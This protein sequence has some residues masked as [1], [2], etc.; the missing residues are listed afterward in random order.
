MPGRAII[1]IRIDNSGSVDAIANIRKAMDD[2]GVSVVGVKEAGD[3]QDKALQKLLNSL[4]PTRVASEKL[5][6]SQ[7]ILSDAYA[8]GKI[9]QERFATNLDALNAKYS[10]H[11]SALDGLKNSLGDFGGLLDGLSS[12]LASFVGPAAIVAGVA[13]LGKAMVDAGEAAAGDEVVQARLTATWTANAGAAGITMEALQSLAQSLSDVSGMSLESIKNAEAL[14]LTFHDVTGN[15]FERMITDATD[16]AA[17]LGTDVGSAVEKLGRALENPV[18]GMN[19]LT[20]AGV[21]FTAAEKEQIKAVAQSG[22]LLGAQNAILDQVESRF[23][24]AAATIGDTTTGAW[25][26]FTNALH[27]LNVEVGKVVLEPAKV[28]LTSATDVV[29]EST[30]RVVQLKNAWQ[31]LKDFFEALGAGES[32]GTAAGAAWAARQGYSYASLPGMAVQ[33]PTQNGQ[34]VPLSTVG[35][36]SPTAG[37]AVGSSADYKNLADSA[38]QLT[39]SLNPLIAA[40]VAEAAAEKT[41]NDALAAG[42]LTPQRYTQL[43]AEEKNNLEATAASARS[44]YDAFDP[45]Q[46]AQDQYT[47]SVTNYNKE[48]LQGVIS[49]TQLAAAIAGAKQKLADATDAY[50]AA[51]DAAKTI[52]AAMDPLRQQTIDYNTSI[53]NL[54]TAVN[55]GRISQTDFAAALD[56]VTG[57]F[58]DQVA[59]MSGYQSKVA[60]LLAQVDPLAKAQADYNDK[61]DALNKLYDAGK[62]P[63]QDYI[64]G[65][66]LLDTN[67]AN[68][69]TPAQQLVDKVQ[70][71][72]DTM[73]QSTAAQ[74]RYNKGMAV[75]DQYLA[76]LPPNADLAIAAIKALNQQLSDA[77]KTTTEKNPFSEF[78]KQ[79]STTIEQSLAGGDFKKLWSSLWS[80]L[81]KEA[82][83]TLEQALFGGKGPLGSNVGGLLGGGTPGASGYQDVTGTQ[84]GMAGAGVVGSYFYGRG[85]Q[86]GNQGEGALGGALSGAATGF[87]MSAGNP[88]ATVAAAIIGAVMGYEGSAGPKDYS[89]DFSA[90]TYQPPDWF[91]KWQQD[92]TSGN[93]YVSGGVSKG[94]VADTQSLVQMTAQL[95]EKSSSTEDSLNDLLVLLNQKAQLNPQWSATL[96]GSTSDVSTAFNQFLNNTMPQAVFQA[97][98][99]PLEAGLQ[100]LGVSADKAAAEMA[101]VSSASDF[102]TA[103]ASLK[104]YVQALLDFGKITTELDKPLSQLIADASEG[105]VQKW[106]DG[107]AS[108]QT[109]I[110]NILA[111]FSTLSSTDQ[112]T[113]ANNAITLINNQIA[114]NQT[115]MASLV[116]LSKSIGDSIQTIFT[117]MDLQAA[118][119]AGTSQEFM[120]GKFNQALAAV[121]G[122]TTEEDL[123][124]AIS[125]AEQ[126]GQQILQLS[127]TMSQMLPQFDTLETTFTNLDDDL[128]SGVGKTL[129]TFFQDAMQNLE[130]STAATADQIENLRI[131][132]D[133]LAPADQIARLQEIGQLAQQQYDSN[134]Q[135]LQ[136]IL[137]LEQTIGDSITSTMQSFDEQDAMAKGSK[138][139]SEYLI[140][141]MMTEYSSLQNGGLTPDQVNSLISLIESQSNTLYGMKDKVGLTDSSGKSID[142]TTWLDN[143][144]GAA[145]AAAQKDLGKN[146]D[147]VQD[148]NTKLAKSISGLADN[149]VLEK[150]ALQKAIDAITTLVGT[151]LGGALNTA[152]LDISKWEQSI[153]DSNA[154]LQKEVN[155]FETALQTLTDAANNAANNINTGAGPGGTAPTTPHGTGGPSGNPKDPF[156][157]YGHTP[158]NP[159]P[160]GDDYWTG[161]QSLGATVGASVLQFNSSLPKAGHSLAEL[162][163]TTDDLTRVHAAAAAAASD[164]TAMIQIAGANLA[165]A[166]ATFQDLIAKAASGAKAAGWA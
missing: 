15:A 118:T 114:A 5:A 50:K 147:L 122:A 2:L 148:A 85:Q 100:A 51:A 47:I 97:F 78:E 67:L 142:M 113:A 94:G 8:D 104:A 31:G 130:T 128:Q 72:A 40:Q 13:A 59:G 95:A 143:L 4:E 129:T 1:E 116:S 96:G 7:K 149:I 87:E 80:D 157:S 76:T 88:Y 73:D 55:A 65:Q 145:N 84:L 120:T 144:L 82:A 20:R 89:T 159:T 92:V 127:Q 152:N 105:S 126:W 165:S 39:Q 132:L 14:G 158:E 140:N 136:K 164:F 135:E 137:Q 10:Q 119:T 155:A 110:G 70:A 153:V 41:L 64:A 123:Q 28:A 66:Q 134:I 52:I 91:T 141:Q 30:D 117:N 46:K 18:A 99:T 27:Q 17:V 53:D 61:V 77:T 45:L 48:A 11:T 16:M 133:Q 102:S 98:T 33:P 90:G 21:S 111:D 42:L 58:N 71:I 160:I 56:Y 106:A 124:T 166:A 6:A 107:L 108:T 109:A 26:K 62:I 25:N 93:V 81:S 75:V 12:K 9:S 154:A 161:T 32:L 121:T 36:V 43:L 69:E 138:Q 115:L 156:G 79:L 49:T 44:A 24:N 34:P 68:V 125:S 139:G 54:V 38:A 23:K 163:S 162:S 101:S 19:N 131:G 63:L 86:T 150:G 112:T 29:K 35:A 22:D 57:K 37:L 103:L 83:S 3:Q 146:V 74:D 60:D 151:G